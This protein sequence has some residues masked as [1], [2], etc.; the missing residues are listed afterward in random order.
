MG[1]SSLKDK[2]T[3]ITGAGDGIG[4]A[5][6]KLF[7]EDGAKVVLVGRTEEKLKNTMKEILSEH[8]K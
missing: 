5:T 1:K 2:V 3:I 7:A 8:G 4:K 6:A